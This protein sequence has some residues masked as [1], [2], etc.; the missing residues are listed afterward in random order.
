MICVSVCKHIYIYI[1]LY[2]DTCIFVILLSLLLALFQSGITKAIAVVGEAAAELFEPYYD[3]ILSLGP[4][5]SEVFGAEN[6][7]R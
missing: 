2:T 7:R 4:I 1:Y 6:H 5:F 3:H